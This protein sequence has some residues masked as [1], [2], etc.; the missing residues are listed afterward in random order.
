MSWYFKF[1][2]FTWPWNNIFKHALYSD[3]NDL[4]LNI[5]FCNVRGLVTPKS[6]V[7]KKPK[8][9]M[10]KLITVKKLLNREKFDVIIFIESWLNAYMD[11]RKVFLSANYKIVRHDRTSL[12]KSRYKKRLEEG[13]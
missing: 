8:F 6:Q 9:I 11:L 2:N 13:F 1:I 5:Y 4:N 3:F 12:D 10:S 7:S